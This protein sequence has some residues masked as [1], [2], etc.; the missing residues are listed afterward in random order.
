MHSFL[1]VLVDEFYANHKKS[2]PKCRSS[3]NTDQW[4]IDYLYYTGRFGYYERT[5]TIPWG[6]GPVNTIGRPC[7]KDGQHS[8]DGMTIFDQNGMILNIHEPE[9]SPARIAPSVHKYGR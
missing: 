4:T 8:Q 7:Y 6:I 1:S 9:D 3:H 5:K 2:N